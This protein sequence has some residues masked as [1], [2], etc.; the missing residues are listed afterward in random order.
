M[1]DNENSVGSSDNDEMPGILIVIDDSE[2][3]DTDENSDVSEAYE[4][5][6]ISEAIEN[7][8]IF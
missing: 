4:N 1:F 6:D 7:S 2:I 3:P 8:D 5:G